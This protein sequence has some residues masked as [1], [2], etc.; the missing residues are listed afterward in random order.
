MFIILCFAHSKCSIHVCRK[1]KNIKRAGRDKVS[2][3]V[4]YKLSCFLMTIVNSHRPFL[5]LPLTP[6]SWWGNSTC[7]HINIL[8]SWL[9][10]KEWT[11]RNQVIPFRGSSENNMQFIRHRLL[12][13]VAG[14][15]T[16]Q[17]Q[18]LAIHPWRGRFPAREGFKWSLENPLPWSPDSTFSSGVCKWPWVALV[19]TRTSESLVDLQAWPQ[20]PD[21]L[22]P[23]HLLSSCPWWTAAAGRGQLFKPIHPSPHVN[24]VSHS[25]NSCS[26]WQRE[27]V[28]HSS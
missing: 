20:P 6:Q 26:V 27:G 21:G 7:L 10:W 2:A 4:I 22:A 5:P 25:T 13:L 24:T 9:L 15:K 8:V 16:Y 1:K 14:I 11:E 18:N 19:P 12:N 23:A 17:L 3:K 28:R